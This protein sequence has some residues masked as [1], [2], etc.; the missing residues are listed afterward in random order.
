[1][2]KEGCKAILSLA[3]RVE[4]LLACDV[5]Q[6]LDNDL[7]YTDIQ[8]TLEKLTLYHKREEIANDSLVPKY[9]I[10]DECLNINQ[11]ISLYSNKLPFKSVY[12]QRSKLQGKGI[13]KVFK[14]KGL[15]SYDL[16]AY[17]KGIEDYLERIEAD[18]TRDMNI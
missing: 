16:N 6:T 12:N 7:K 18:V 15:Y 4:L 9:N 11:Y 17:Y 10:A 3:E 14:D 1:M 2:K 8:E 13:D 5:R